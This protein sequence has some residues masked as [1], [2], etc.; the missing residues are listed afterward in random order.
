MATQ[1]KD[2][3]WL[4]FPDKNYFLEEFDD[5]NGKLPAIISS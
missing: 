3:R 5:L 1:L 4:Y 2:N